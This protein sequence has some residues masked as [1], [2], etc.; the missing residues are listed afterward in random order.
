MKRCSYLTQ[1]ESSIQIKKISLDS[2]LSQRMHR[3]LLLYKE[4]CATIIATRKVIN[5]A[6]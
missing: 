6:N 3:N 4:P 1:G 2:G 5:F